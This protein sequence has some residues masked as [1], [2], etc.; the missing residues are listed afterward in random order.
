MLGFVLSLKIF[1]RRLRETN[2][3]DSFAGTIGTF[4][5]YVDREFT[6]IKSWAVS[7]AVQIIKKTKSP[8]NCWWLLP[9]QSNVFDV[10]L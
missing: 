3:K 2:S 8:N 1:L 7:D 5:A 4:V 6:D 9:H 10:I